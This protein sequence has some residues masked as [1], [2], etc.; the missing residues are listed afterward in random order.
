MDRFERIQKFDRFIAM[1]GIISKL[2]NRKVMVAERIIRNM[3]KMPKFRNMEELYQ[4]ALSAEKNTY[5]CREVNGLVEGLHYILQIDNDAPSDGGKVVAMLK[6]IQRSVGKAQNVV[7]EYIVNEYNE[8]EGESGAWAWSN[9]D[10][11]FSPRKVSDATARIR[12]EAIDILVNVKGVRVTLWFDDGDL[13]Y[14][15]SIVV[16]DLFDL[17]GNMSKDTMTVSIEG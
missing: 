12:L 7:A 4:A 9:T 14:G 17:S 10:E 16:S 13:W 6:K 5:E 1:E 3:D 2:S 8:S 15:H 11:P